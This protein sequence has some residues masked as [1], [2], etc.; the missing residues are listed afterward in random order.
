MSL[1]TTLTS[2]T[3]LMFLTLTRSARRPF[4]PVNLHE[5]SFVG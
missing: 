1:I 2:P 3:W 5:Q 4:V